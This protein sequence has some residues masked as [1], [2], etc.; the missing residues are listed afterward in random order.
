MDPAARAPAPRAAPTPGPWQY[1]TMRPWWGVYATSIDERIA[2]CDTEA[3]ARLIAASPD[4]LAAAEALVADAESW[5]TIY[6]NPDVPQT[7][8]EYVEVGVALVDRLRAAIDSARGVGDRAP[9]A[10]RND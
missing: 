6:T 8:E 4:L 9:A 1:S 7:A 2:D 5:E 10:E 3:N